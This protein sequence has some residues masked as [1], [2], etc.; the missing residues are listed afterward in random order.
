MYLLFKKASID[1]YKLVSWLTSVTCQ[2]QSPLLLQIIIYPLAQ[3]L[4]FVKILK[5][6]YVFFIGFSII[7]LLNILIIND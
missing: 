1:H 4:Y 7:K 5:Q 3:P 6:E 2:N